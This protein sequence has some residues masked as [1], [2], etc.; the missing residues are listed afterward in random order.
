MS[1]V[2][3]AYDEPSDTLFVHFYGRGRPGV[4]VDMNGHTFVRVDAETGQVLGLQIE[5]ALRHVA[6]QNPAILVLAE[7]A[8]ASSEALAR[9]RPQTAAAAIRSVV[10]ELQPV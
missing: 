6:Q 4:S 7:A 3:L 9:V 2:V 8:G 10:R 5:G 1:Q